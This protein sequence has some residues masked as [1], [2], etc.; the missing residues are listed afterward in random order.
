LVESTSQEIAFVAYDSEFGHGDSN[1][2]YQKA[3]QSKTGELQTFGGEDEP[4]LDRLCS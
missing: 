3:I 4:A 2:E 1:P